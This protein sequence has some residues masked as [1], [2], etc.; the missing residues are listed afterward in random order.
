MAIFE[1]LGAAMWAARARGQLGRVGLRRAVV[2]DGL[3]P[4]QERVAEL[5]VAGIDNREIAATLFMSVR[6]VESHPTKAY[7]E[8]GVRSAP[9]S[10]QHLPRKPKQTTPVDSHRQAAEHRG[11]AMNTESMRVR[12]RESECRRLERVLADP[13]AWP[14]VLALQGAAGIG[15]STVGAMPSPRPA[16]AAFK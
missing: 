9:S 3:T 11:N 6:S 1:P 16:R 7:R 13:G 10:P 15:K 5:V 12:G 14:A 4:A 8:L 2:S